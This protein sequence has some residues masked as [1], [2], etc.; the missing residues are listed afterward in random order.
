MPHPLTGLA[1]VLLR[2]LAAAV[3]GGL[4]GFERD[5]HGRA[6]GLRTHLLVTL[7]AALFMILSL[8]VSELSVGRFADPGRIAAQIVTGIGFLGA[9]AILKDGL[10][11]RG[12]TTAACLWIAAAI[13]M[14]AG[15]G[16]YLLAAVT[17]GIALVALVLLKRVER[18]Y[19]KDDYRFLTVTTPLTVASSRV[20]DIVKRED[21]T[22]LSCEIDKDYERELI[23]TR[24][25]IRLLEKGAT[26]KL[27][28]RIIQS[29]E[30]S[31]LGLK[32][33]R[34]DHS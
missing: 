23:V 8:A 4:V 5:L 14:A 20:I 30:G 27:A 28:H 26:D 12:L 32:E 24:L 6:A 33:I 10:N 17:T 2:L 7:G 3:L 1:D 29:L 21:L 22:I 13:G 16:A 9:G 25:S 11:I 19:A 31:S 34:W 18:F 15:A